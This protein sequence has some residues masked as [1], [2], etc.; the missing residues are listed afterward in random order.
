MRETDYVKPRA[1]DYSHEIGTN[2][3]THKPHTEYIIYMLAS[4]M[5]IQQHF[6]SMSHSFMEKYFNELTE[7]IGMSPSFMII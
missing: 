4:T 7:Q 1:T 6:N 3:Q 5:V 2:T